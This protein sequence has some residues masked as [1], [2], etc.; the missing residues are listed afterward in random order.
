[1]PVGVDS[2]KKRYLT[3]KDGKLNERIDQNTQYDYGFIEGQI[4]NITFQEHAEYG[5]QIHLHLIDQQDYFVLQ[6]YLNSYPAKAF[7]MML[8]NIDLREL[9]KISVRQTVD[10]NVKRIALF[11]SQDFGTPIKWYW[12]KEH[13][14]GLPALV[15]IKTR[16]KQGQ[17]VDGWDDTDRMN[18]LQEM[19]KNEIVPQLQ[20]KLSPY[21]N[22]PSYR[23]NVGNHI[24][25]NHFGN[26][27]KIRVPNNGGQQI[28]PKS[29]T[30]PLDDLPF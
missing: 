19:V 27:D 9:L 15:P 12:N 24:A 10:N 20:K 3:I 16:N 21:P 26:E 18:F 7:L 11:C 8:K 4:M 30:E 13:Q 23:S 17:L 6:M 29:I 22:H 2:G 1:M 14:V 5:K 28:D 25:G